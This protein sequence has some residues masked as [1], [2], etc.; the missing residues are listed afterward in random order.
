MQHLAWLR[1]AHLLLLLLLHLPPTQLPVAV[2]LGLALLFLQQRQAGGR[3][4]RKF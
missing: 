1:K 2:L 4:G 3:L